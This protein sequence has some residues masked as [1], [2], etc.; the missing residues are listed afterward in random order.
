MVQMRKSAG[1]DNTVPRR[2]VCRLTLLKKMT[3]ITLVISTIITDYAR[4]SYPK[5][6]ALK[7]HQGPMMHS[8][9]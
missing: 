5:K 8:E 6:T 1:E 4:S 9:I 2:D 7:D 3:V